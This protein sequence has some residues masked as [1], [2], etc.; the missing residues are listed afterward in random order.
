MLT[1]RAEGIPA[2][3]ERDLF[4][5]QAELALEEFEHGFVGVADGIVSV[6]RLL[7]SSG[8]DFGIAGVRNAIR[9]GDLDIGKREPAGCEL[10]PEERHKRFAAFGL[11]VA[12]VAFAAG[13]GLIHVRGFFVGQHGIDPAENL[14]PAQAVG[15]DEDDVLGAGGIGR[16]EQGRERAEL[17]GKSGDEHIGMVQ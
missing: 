9:V 3:Q 16:G 10:F 6:N 8:Q 12:P 5:S 17:R 13:L 2:R 15:G 14:L 7:N 4:F 1:D 11:G